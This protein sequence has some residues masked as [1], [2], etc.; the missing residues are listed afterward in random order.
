M[1]SIH[2]DLLYFLQCVCVCRW[3][4]DRLPLFNCEKGAAYQRTAI[5]TDNVT[6]ILRFVC[7]CAHGIDALSA[8][9]FCRYSSCML[10]GADV[11]LIWGFAGG[12]WENLSLSSYLFPTCVCL[13]T[14][15]VRV[16]FFV[17]HWSLIRPLL[18]T[19]TKWPLR[20]CWWV[21]VGL[22]QVSPPSLFFT[23]PLF[24][25]SLHFPGSL[26]YYILFYES[27]SSLM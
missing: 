20:R 4:P 6:I 23:F 22:S 21:S 7:V 17:C 25:V 13:L 12:K 1:H 10:D 19:Y 16:C 9:L 2:Y 26:T 24:F 27:C 5:K 8:L 3:Q 15:C 18:T 11:C 14:I